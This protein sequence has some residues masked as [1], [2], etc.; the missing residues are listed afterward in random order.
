MNAKQKSVLDR[1]KHLEEAII[2]GREFLATGAHAH[3]HGFRPLTAGKVKDDK[4]LPPNKNWVQNVFLPRSE[5][6]LRQAEKVLASLESDG[7]D[8]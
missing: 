3:W 1:I 5:R 7:T 8:S 2:K 6:A 4:P